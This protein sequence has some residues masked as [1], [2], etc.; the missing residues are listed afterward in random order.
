MKILKGNLLQLALDGNFDVIIHGCNCMC[1]MGAGIARQI[2]QH[3][4]D[5]YKAD[6]ATKS[7]DRKKLGTYTSAEVE[8]AGVHY[9]VINAYTQYDF[10]GR[11]VNVDYDAVRSCFRAIRR[12]F[13]GKR[14]GYPM[15]GAGLAGGN[16]DTIAAIIDEELEGE[17]HTLVIFQPGS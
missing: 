17:D 10:G 11:K 6:Q 8:R 15:I 1:T 16:W 14:I 2:K 4:P 5:A 9:T 13:A 12:D 7:G 3:F